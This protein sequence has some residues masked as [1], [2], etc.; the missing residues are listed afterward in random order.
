[1]VIVREDFLEDPL[2]VRELALSQFRSVYDDLTTDGEGY[3]PG[4]RV[5]LPEDLQRDLISKLEIETGR[6]ILSFS[7]AFHLTTA[8]HGFGLIHQD[9]TRFSGLVYLNEEA[10]PHSGTL[11]CEL[12][13][14]PLP[15]IHGFFE[16][17]STSD[18]NAI[19]SFIQTKLVYNTTHFK[20]DRKIDNRFN[21]MI[22]YEGAR[23]HAPGI[24]FGSTVE[25]SRLVLVFW[26]NVR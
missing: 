26:F 3:Y 15:Q 8:I 1:M 23:P 19:E 22:V 9:S 17:S 7:C 6:Q 4:V 10:P 16:A 14:E 2:T 21:R 12:N 18:R 25:D 5:D 11:L 20:I 13:T 24:Y